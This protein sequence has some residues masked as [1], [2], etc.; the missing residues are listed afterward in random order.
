M[1]YL[2]LARIH[3]FAILIF[4][5]EDVYA[6]VIIGYVNNGPGSNILCFKHFFA[7]EIIDLKG[8]VFIGAL[9]EVEGDLRNGGVGVKA[10]DPDGWLSLGIA[11]GLAFHLN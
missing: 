2:E 5:A 8:I 1:R 9:F 11:T 10:G 7:Y 6:P 4:Q 3:H